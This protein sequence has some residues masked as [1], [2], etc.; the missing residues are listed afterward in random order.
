MSLSRREFLQ[1]L[2]M[3]AAAGLVFE[4]GPGGRQAF[5][6]SKKPGS[7]Y[8]VAPFGNVTLLHMTDSHAQLLPTYFR[9]PNINIGVGAARG[10][11]PH[12]VGAN[13]LKHFNIT[14]GSIEAHPFTFL[15]S[16]APARRNQGR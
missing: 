16:G 2:A 8:D 11:P 4:G 6:G 5:A 1:V 12:L 13:L 9:E 3:G 10:K 7:L 14:P 15:V